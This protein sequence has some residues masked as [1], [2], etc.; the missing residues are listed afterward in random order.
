MPSHD[1]KYL[2][3]YILYVYFTSVCINSFLILLSLFFIRYNDVRSAI[4]G[5]Y[6]EPKYQ[7]MFV[8]NK[9]FN[10]P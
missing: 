2:L 5:I 3:T 4:N 6:K 7:G 10:F 8:R 9:M 1:N